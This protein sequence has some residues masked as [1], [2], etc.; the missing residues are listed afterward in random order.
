MFHALPMPIRAVLFDAD[1]VLQHLPEGLDERIIRTLGRRPEPF[2]DFKQAVYAAER[3]SLIGEAHF[4]DALAEVLS[5]WHLPTGCID[6][7]LDA[8]WGTL[9]VDTRVLDRI[10]GL[11]RAGFVC[12]LATN[13]QQYRAHH[14]AQVLGYAS[15][16]DH[17][18]YSCRVGLA[19]PDPAFFTHIATMLESEPAQLLFLDDQPRNVDGAR[20]AGLHAEQFFNDQTAAAMETLTALLAQ[21][22]VTAEPS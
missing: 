6:A 8:W 9:Q 16:F 17:A 22:A 11:R 12:A 3:P 15:R 19:K 13:Q 7:L 4:R 2:E 21:H 10:D 14:M 20:R 1:G 18:F 5:D